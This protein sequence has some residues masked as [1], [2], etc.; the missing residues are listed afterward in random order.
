MARVVGEDWAECVGLVGGRGTGAPERRGTSSLGRSEAAG[1]LDAESPT[2]GEG[3]RTRGT[4][5]RA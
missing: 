1:T 2:V 3:V 5:T 4:R